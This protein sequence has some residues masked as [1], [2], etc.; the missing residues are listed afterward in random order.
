MIAFTGLSTAILMQL[1]KTSDTSCGALL[2][3]FSARTENIDGNILAM[4]RATAAD[5]NIAAT[6]STRIGF[7][8]APAPLV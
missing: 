5:K 8:F 1:I 2:V 3:A 7:N 4:K 6:Y